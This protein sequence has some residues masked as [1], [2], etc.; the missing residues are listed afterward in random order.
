MQN[1]CGNRAPGLV[2]LER[3]VLHPALRLAERRMVS[4]YERVTTISSWVR[5]FGVDVESELKNF[6]RQA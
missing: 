4:R 3:E 1:N 6:M 5:V 2:G